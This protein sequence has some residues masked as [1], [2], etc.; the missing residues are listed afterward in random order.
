[1]GVFESYSFGIGWWDCGVGG[2]GTQRKRT[3]G[4]PL[5]TAWGGGAVG[6]EP[7]QTFK[8]RPLGKY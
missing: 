4:V 6:S 1:M 5:P 7:A 8:V 2:F 3:R